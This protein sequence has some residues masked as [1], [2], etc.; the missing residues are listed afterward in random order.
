MKRNSRLSLTDKTTAALEDIG[1]TKTE[2]K[3]YLALLEK[4][5]MPASE[6]SRVGRIPYSKVYDALEALRKKGWVEAQR[7]R[8]ILYTARPPDSALEELRSRQES[9]RREKEQLILQDLKGIYEQRGQQERP[10][11]WIL[12]GN[13]EILARVK[14]TVLNSKRELMIALPTILAPFTKQISTLLAAMKEKG[15]KNLILTSSDAPKGS[16]DD[17][18]EVAELRIRGTMFGGGVVADAKEVVLLLGGGESANSSLAIWAD[19]PGLAS[20]AR[21][22][23]QFLWSSQETVKAKVKG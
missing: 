18:M 3:A 12:R 13:N 6:V 15:V 2:I 8:P 19:H 21:D 16:L 17:L 1:L 4:G 11:V 9:D 10:E 20:F 7:S 5:T 14:N 23:F 22:Y